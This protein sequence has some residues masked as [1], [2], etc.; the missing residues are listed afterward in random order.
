M[1]KNI[2]FSFLI[3]FMCSGCRTFTSSQLKVHNQKIYESGQIDGIRKGIWYERI[4]RSERILKNLKENLDKL[5]KR[6]R[7]SNDS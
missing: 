7:I 2:I 5:D 4:T 6:L 3:I 1:S